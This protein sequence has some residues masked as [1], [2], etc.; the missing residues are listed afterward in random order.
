MA[1]LAKSLGVMLLVIPDTITQSALV[2]PLSRESWERLRRL[3][4]KVPAPKTASPPVIIDSSEIWP[5]AVYESAS[6]PNRLI[7]CS[8]A[9][10]PSSSLSILDCS[11]RASPMSSVRLIF[12]PGSIKE[13]H[14]G[15]QQPENPNP[16]SKKTDA[17]IVNISDLMI[18][19]NL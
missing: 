6:E 7:N 11:S 17:I 4:V 13:L 5:V 19:C 18:A 15:R 1:S 9:S 2:V 8:C 12:F 16:V 14:R 10:S 3:S